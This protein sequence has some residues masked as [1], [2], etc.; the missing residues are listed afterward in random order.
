M[1][2]T[3]QIASMLVLVVALVLLVSCKQAPVT[4]EA[5][6]P[7]VQEISTAAD[8]LQDLNDLNNE[9][10]LDTDFQDLEDA[11]LN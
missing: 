9:L 4:G 1:N 10:N 11:P 6:T 5:A 8:D 3:M 7:E 2:K